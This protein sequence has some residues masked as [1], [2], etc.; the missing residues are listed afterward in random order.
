M[1]NEREDALSTCINDFPRQG[2]L[3]SGL[4]TVYWPNHLISLKKNLFPTWLWAVASRFPN[5]RW[6]EFVNAERNLWEVT[7]LFLDCHIFADTYNQFIKDRVQQSHLGENRNIQDTIIGERSSF[8]ARMLVGKAADALS[9]EEIIAE[10]TGQ[11]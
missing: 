9:Q 5:S 10:T 11:M 3:V 6:Q 7:K 8:V 4:N 2:V 1:K